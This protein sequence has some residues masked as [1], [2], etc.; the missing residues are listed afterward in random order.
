MSQTGGA[1][2]SAV[3]RLRYDIGQERYAAEL[4]RNAIGSSTM[5][6]RCCATP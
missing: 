6:R 1:L 2:G 3:K 4:P 5:P